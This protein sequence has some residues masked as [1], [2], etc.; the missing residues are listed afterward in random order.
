V[1]IRLP[2]SEVD[3]AEFEAGWVGSGQLLF[4][5]GRGYY[6]RQR[7]FWHNVW[8]FENESGEIVTQF[9]NDLHVFKQKV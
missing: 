5:D 6:W 3:T 4:A 9:R 2:G 1:T 8:A 7:I